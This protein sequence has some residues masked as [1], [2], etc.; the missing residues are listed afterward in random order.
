MGLYTSSVIVL[1]MSISVDYIM[2][3]V[4]L[5]TTNCMSEPSLTAPEGLDLT[6]MNHFALNKLI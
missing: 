6:H 4:S 2:L 1:T 5:H 3:S